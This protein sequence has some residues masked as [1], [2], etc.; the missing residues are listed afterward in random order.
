MLVLIVIHSSQGDLAAHYGGKKHISRVK[1]VGAGQ[2][3]D[4]CIP[5]AATT[6][7]AATFADAQVKRQKRSEMKKVGHHCALCIHLHPSR[8]FRRLR[9]GVM[10][11]QV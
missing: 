3:L 9:S 2:D 10:M 7:Y 5:H 11:L 4:V 8:S 6:C 1:K